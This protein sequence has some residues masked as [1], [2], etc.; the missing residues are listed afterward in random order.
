[1]GDEGR[2]KAARQKA[3]VLTM[4]GACVGKS[5]GWGIP[6]RGQEPKSLKKKENRVDLN[7]SKI[8][9]N[10]RGKHNKNLKNGVAIVP[11]IKM[12]ASLGGTMICF[13]HKMLKRG[14]QGSTQLWGDANIEP[15]KK[16]IE[17]IQRFIS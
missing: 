17:I 7:K 11:T 9:A 13:G 5:G 15:T 8:N 12:G 3:L 2:G 4:A 14:F 6:K 10:T 16:K 1:M